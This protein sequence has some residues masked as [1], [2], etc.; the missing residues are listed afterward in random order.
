M[1]RWRQ[2]AVLHLQ[3]PFEVAELLAQNLSCRCSSIIRGWV[4]RQKSSRGSSR[5]CRATLSR[6]TPSL[7]FG[8]YNRHNK[9]S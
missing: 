1:G 2:S 4:L 3:V 6:A 8:I 5:R 9:T 7:D